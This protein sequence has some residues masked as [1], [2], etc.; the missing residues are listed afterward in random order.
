MDK[1]I[2]YLKKSQNEDGSWGKEP[3]NR[4]VTGIVV[5]GLIGTGVRARRC[6]GRQ[7]RRSSSSR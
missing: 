2:A 1:A 3:Q 7:G 6:A 5:T 4:G